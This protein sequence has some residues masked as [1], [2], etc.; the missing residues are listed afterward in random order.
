[1][2][3]RALDQNVMILCIWRHFSQVDGGAVL[4]AMPK[5]PLWKL[6]KDRRQFIYSFEIYPKFIETNYRTSA[7]V[8]LFATDFYPLRS[9]H[10]CSPSFQFETVVILW[11]LELSNN[12]LILL[13]NHTKIYDRSFGG[14][15]PSQPPVFWLPTDLSGLRHHLAHYTIAQMIQFCSPYSCLICSH[16]HNRTSQ[17]L[18]LSWIW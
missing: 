8:N 1:M 13:S 11:H 17:Q 12:A 5:M 18:R 14:K 4:S 2:L 16:R 15:H 6:T 10:F 7:N 9:S 3:D